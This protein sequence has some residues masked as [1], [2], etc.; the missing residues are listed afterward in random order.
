MADMFRW[1]LVIALA[2]LFVAMGVLHFVPSVA[3][4]MSAI[5]PPALKA[6]VSGKALVQ[7]TGLCE[8]VGGIGLLVPATQAAAAIALV[9]FLIAVFPANEFAA[10]HPER[11][12]RAAVPFWPRYAAQLVLVGLCL[13][14]LV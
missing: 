5:I 2:L 1:V 6:R 13:L 14:V 7:L 9:V 4:G 8:I 12:G 11:F 3:K 10:R